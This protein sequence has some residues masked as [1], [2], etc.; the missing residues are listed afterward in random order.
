[1]DQ[2]RPRVF[3]V[4]ASRALST[5]NLFWSMRRIPLVG[6]LL[7]LL[8]ALLL[9]TSP[10]AAQYFGRNKVQYDDFD[11]RVLPTEHFEV[12]FYPEEKEATSDAARMAERWYSRHSKTFLRTFN[13][14]KPLIFYA[15]DAD[16]Q[17]TNVIGGF[18]GQGT[19]GVT[20][21]LKQRVVMPLTGSY[22]D[23]DH[24][25]GH[26]L[27]HSF[28]YDIALSG[29]DSVRFNLG[30]IPLW[31]VEGMAEY[32]SI[33]RVDSHT[34][35]WL[36]DAALR[37]D[38]PTATQL[39]RD[40]RYFPYRYGQALMAY[41]GGKYGDA[42]VAN[43]F[44][45]AGRTGLDSAFVY[46]LGIQADSLSNE[47][48]ETI[49]ETY[50]PLTEGRAPADSAGRRVLSEE[51]TGGR[52]NI[53][54][55]ISPDG[56]YIAFLSE[57]DL[58]NINLFV[59]DAE[60]GEV[61]KRLKGTVTDPHFD[62][63]RFISSAGS[64]SPD[65]KR[66]AFVTFVQG[67]NEIAILDVD[68][69]EVERRFTVEGVGAITNPAWSPDGETIAFSGMDGGLSDLYLLDVETREVRQLTDDRYA[70]MQPAWSPDGETLAFV[71]D[72]GPGGSN[73]ETLEFSPMGLATISTRG[74]EPTV[75]RPFGEALHHNPQFSPDGRSLFF[76]SDQDGF[77][78][79]Y[80]L[81]LATG[82]PHRI[83]HLQ[84]GV[85]GITAM[86]PAMSVAA[87]SGRMVFSVFQN[88]TY[89]VYA[90][91]DDE[92]EGEPVEALAEDLIATA[93]VLPPIRALG[94]GLVE[95][96]LGSPRLGLPPPQEGA[97]KDY[98]PRLRLDYVA[99][100]TVGVSV[101]G[102]YGG[103]VGGG[104][105]F[106]FSDMLGNQ[107][108]AI[109]AQANGTYKDIGA[110]V[111]Y[112]N[113]KNRINYGAS[114]GHIPILFGNAFYDFAG[115]VPRYNL[116]RQRIFIDQLSL[117]AAYPLSTTRRF[118]LNAGVVRYGFDNEL[119]RYT[120]F[121][122]ERINGD[123]VEPGDP[124]YRFLRES[125]PIYFFSSTAAFVVDYSNFGFTSP[126]Q[127]GRYRF[128][129]TPQVGS[130]N[131]VTALADVRRY[132]FRKPFTFAVR[133][134]HVGNYGARESVNP[135][136]G[137]RL[138]G[139]EYLGSSYYPGFIR[140]YSFSSLEQDECSIPQ[141]FTPQNPDGSINPTPCP[142]Y[143]RL[144]GTRIGMASAEIRLPVF[145]TESLGLINFP[146][147]P[148]E[149]SLFADA[150]IAWTSDT[151]PVL[152]FTTDEQTLA[153]VNRRYPLVS[154]GASTRLNVLGYMVFEIFYAYPFQRPEKGPHFGFALSPGW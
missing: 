64:W 142:E 42:A 26:E 49:K 85:S 29:R 134:L 50:L 38:I 16:F 127:G 81:D 70:D 69:R 68:S 39:T 46:A 62:A 145:G 76:I 18:I 153:D 91:E 71:T 61:I 99:P 47:W 9:G 89:N 66:L 52:M 10:A 45:L 5:S 135:N 32:L 113:R 124:L 12:Y 75:L 104:V 80:R 82:E 27:V 58:F 103:G 100:P 154:V 59:A 109:V 30:L 1:M 15:N 141:G 24:V 19:G 88:N 55:T 132:V 67:D 31:V 79:V 22:A 117:D 97:V 147:L 2:E 143:D 36:R 118:E 125:D 144:Y 56:K 149:L 129:A 123:D 112:L 4:L 115:G 136:E 25:L 54:P 114:G 37:D 86:S 96:Y 92:L 77:K 33:G 21:G 63:I 110:Q 140:G 151:T 107:N 53:A 43:L 148:T 121:G 3:L 138:Y 7:V 14:K 65:G 83:T 8:A 90:L 150:G 35:M 87:Q 95:R 126:V 102:P 106:Y 44:K 74:G 101:G 23:T 119:D 94:E 122:R 137:S 72:R 17:Q 6:G 93:K 13:E 98:S 34:A 51:A 41:V 105:G 48:A 84:T 130:D 128:Q 152:K 11:F 20:E 131:F 146:Y 40:T 60:T 111:G 108:L 133:G 28:Q 120:G 57:R 116:I 78:D 73:F 139:R